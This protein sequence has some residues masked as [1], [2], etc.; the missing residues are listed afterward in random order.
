MIQQNHQQQE[1]S[2]EEIPLSTSQTILI[3]LQHIFVSNVWLDPIFVASAAGLSLALST[4]LISAIFLASGLVTI[5]QASKLARL[6]IVQ[7]PS[8]AFD[9]LMISAGKTGGLPAAGGAV[10]LSGFIVLLMSLFGW[11]HRLA[12]KLTPAINGTII[13][14]VG[15]SLSSFTM[16]ELLGGTPGTKGFASPN[17][18]LVAVTTTLIV[19]LGSLFGRGYW[20]KFSFLLALVVGNLLAA[21]LG[22]IDLSSVQSQPFFGLPRLFPYG[23]FRFNWAIFLTFFI[24]YLVAVIEALGVYEASA[25]VTKEELSAKRISRGIAG[26]A[27]GS[28]LSSLIGGFP[29]TA[30][31]QNLG[32]MKLTGVHSRKPILLA[33]GLLIL[34]GFVPK[35][36]AVL[37]LTPAPVIGGMF[38]PAAATLLTTG[39]AT[40]QKADKGEATRMSIGLSLLLAI[41]LPSY[42]KGFS[43]IY[44][45]LFS[46]SILVGALSI[47]TL[48]VLLIVVPGFFGGKKNH[49]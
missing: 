8:A 31:A 28:M 35:F 34:L 32:F 42:A 25:D 7:G 39:F 49:E 26:E 24:A 14:L 11:V 23:L 1:S 10:F 36:A 9:A 21:S 38:L 44:Q 16:S 48:H 47:V 3:S 2:P 6:P 40:L 22:M 43:G 17:V 18:L 15:I 45:S 46:N 5:L 20:R 12:K 30:F 41:A 13:F 37:A 27:G 19:V 4:N 29:T 33:G